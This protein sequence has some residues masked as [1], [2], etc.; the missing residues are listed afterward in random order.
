MYT[1]YNT[2]IYIPIKVGYVQFPGRDL[3]I[4]TTH[5]SPWQLKL[6]LE[7]L[8]RENIGKVTELFYMK[9]LALTRR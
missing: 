9:M 7:G 1:Y 3:R 8:S 5:P 6:H 2:Y 4:P